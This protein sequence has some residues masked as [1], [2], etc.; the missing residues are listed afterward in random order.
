MST[1]TVGSDTVIAGDTTSIVLTA[2]DAAGNLI[3]AGGATV[4]FTKGTGTADGTISAVTDAGDGT[5]RAVFTA[6]T[7]GT[8]RTIGVTIGG[9]VG[10]MAAPTVVVRPGRFSVAH[11]SMIPN[12]DTLRRRDTLSVVLV[13]RDSLG[14]AHD[15]GGLT[16]RWGWILKPLLPGA[17]QCFPLSPPPMLDNGDGTY[18][19]NPANINAVQYQ[20]GVQSLLVWVQGEP[21][22]DANCTLQYTR[23]SVIVRPAA[24]AASGSSVVA[25]PRLLEVGDTSTVT[26]TVKD[27]EFYST[28]GGDTVVIVADAATA[29]GTVSP[30]IDRG[31]GTYTARF[32]ANAP[33]GPRSI[34]V[35]VN[36]DTISLFTS[37]TEIL[38]LAPVPDLAISTDSV[39]LLAQQGTIGP[40]VLVAVANAGTGAIGGLATTQA[41][42]SGPGACA[43]QNWLLTPTFD[44]GGI[45]DPVSVMTL[46]AN[47][48]GLELGVCVRRVVVTSTTP[49]VQ[50]ETLLVSLD[51][52]RN[53]VATGLVNVVMMGDAASNTVQTITPTPVL[54]IDNG[55]RG[56]VSNLTASIVSQTGFAE[57]VDPFDEATCV[58]WLAPGDLVFSSPTLPSTL[59]IVSQVRPFAAT[60]RVR[61]AGTGM[62][63]RD[64][65]INVVFNVLPELVTNPRAAIFRAYRGGLYGGP[66]EVTD[67]LIAF[68]Q[69]TAH[70][71]LTNYRVDP[72]APLPSDWRVQV[73][74]FGS[75]ARVIITASV[76]YLPDDTTATSSGLWYSPGIGNGVGEGMH[77]GG[78]RILADCTNPDDCFDFGADSVVPKAFEIPWTVQTARGLALP[79]D[80]IEI[81]ARDTTT[82]VID[83]PITNLGPGVIEDLRID[84]GGGVGGWVETQIVGG[85]TTPAVLRLTVRPA[86]S[87]PTPE[88]QDAVWLTGRSLFVTGQDG[89]RQEVTLRILLHRRFP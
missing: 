51:V 75:S 30:V 59:S 55:G 66:Q 27:S 24:G 7:T 45:A 6:L 21:G 67:T 9:V 41:H 88:Q 82:Q 46:Q 72:N 29:N 31:D 18:R 71:G 14:N 63:A 19:S 89:N 23:D 76:W 35:L 54:R 73:T 44:K 28:Q 65:D 16:V 36:G 58:P 77:T 42:V 48:A 56:T 60:A 3:G 32:I 8:P 11:S 39:G 62:P 50:P 12:G 57:C 38:V 70:P 85:T 79:L 87:E 84:G 22:F 86:R 17:G 37:Q 40:A 83:L 64:F 34:R 69:N 26:V 52:G 74:P 2:R 61:V 1:L 13:A 4:A 78:I 47:A 5:Y 68:N 43:T 20:T 25:A 81:T 33:G 53:P 80:T 49:G 10:T 15:L